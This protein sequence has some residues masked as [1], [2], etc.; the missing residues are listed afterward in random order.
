MVM[1]PTVQDLSAAER[2]RKAIEAER[3]ELQ[4]ELSSGTSSRSA[5]ADDKRRLE[6]RVTQLEEELEEERTQS[7]IMADKFKKM[8]LQVEQL[9]AEVNSERASTQKIENARTQLDKQ[10][11]QSCSL[12]SGSL[13]HHRS[14]T[15]CFRTRIFVTRSRSWSLRSVCAERAPSKRWRA[16]LLLSRNSSILKQSKSNTNPPPPQVIS[17]CQQIEI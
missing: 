12:S 17:F 4:E 16:R 1:F 13:A 3:D 15:V 8:S 14:L 6:G 9:T 7:E 2:A 10:V 11:T 5:L